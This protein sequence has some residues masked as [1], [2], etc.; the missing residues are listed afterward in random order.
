MTDSTF[1][2][3]VDEALKDAFNAAAKAQDRSAA[4]LLRAAMREFVAQ[5]VATQAPEGW[6]ATK[7]RKSRDAITAGEAYDG[8]DMK[9]RFARFRA[10]ARAAVQ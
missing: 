7:V 5:H 1:T 4:Q 9:A 2:F 8:D 10:A 6:L 3:R